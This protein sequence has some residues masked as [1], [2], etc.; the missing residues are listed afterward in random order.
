MKKIFI[1]IIAIIIF[2]CSKDDDCDCKFSSILGIMVPENYTEEFIE[3]LVDLMSAEQKAA[4]DA[5]CQ[6]KCN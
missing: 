3:E 1:L 5:Q 4:V 2:G 6:E